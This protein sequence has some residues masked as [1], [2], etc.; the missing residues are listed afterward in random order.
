MEIDLTLLS[1]LEQL[2]RLRLSDE[3]R[4]NML[5]ELKEILQMVNRLQEVDTE[6]VAPMI[7]GHEQMARLRPDEVS[8]A[9]SSEQ[10]LENAP[11]HDGQHFRVPKVIDR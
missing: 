8:G 2:A 10:A 7:H 5:T 11:D 9:W 6:G 3:D 1:K 4:D